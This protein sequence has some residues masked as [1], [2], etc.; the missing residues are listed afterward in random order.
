MGRQC[1][2]LGIPAQVAGVDIT[3]V[4]V[5]VLALNT[6]TLTHTQALGFPMAPLHFIH[7]Q[8][9]TF[10]SVECLAVK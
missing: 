10:V 7:Y 3:R 9:S 5:G 1:H 4:W 8:S 6:C 2:G